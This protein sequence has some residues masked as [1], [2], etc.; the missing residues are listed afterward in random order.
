MERRKK[1]VI[2]EHS[3]TKASLVTEPPHDYLRLVEET[4]SDAFAESLKKL[5]VFHPINRFYAAGKIFPD[6]VLL[7]VTLHHGEKTLSATTVYASIDFDTTKPSPSINLEDVLGLALDSIGSMFN[8]LL[9]PEE[10]ERLEQI[11]NSSLSAI[12]EAPYEWSLLNEK[13]PVWLKVDKSNL[14]LE[15]L[16]DEWLAKNQ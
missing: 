7:A 5:E 10:S 12:E 1:P 15:K 6:E 3:A 4:L 9:D 13:T 8:Y 11:A 14:V 16:T 2:T